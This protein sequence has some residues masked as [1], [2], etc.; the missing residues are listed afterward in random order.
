MDKKLLRKE[1]IKLRDELSKELK[2]DYDKK[3][4]DIFLNSDLYKNSKEVFVY[5]SFRSEV[6]TKALIQ[7]LLD[8]NK[9]VYVPKI[10]EATND[11]EAIKINSLD[12][13]IENKF[14]TLEPVNLENIIAP[15]EIDLIITPGVAF[16]LLGNR[17][18]YGKGYYDKFFSKISKATTKVALAYDLQIVDLIKVEDSD[19]P[20]D[21]IISESGIKRI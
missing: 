7:K 18:G 2:V 11:M 10:K 3:I 4:L 17:L 5:I 16:D 6:D 13:L 8:D 20:V 21:Y 12:N 19:I 15:N 14:G 9:N 1:K